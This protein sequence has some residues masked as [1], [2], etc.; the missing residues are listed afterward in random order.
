MTNEINLYPLYFAIFICIIFLVFIIS[1]ENKQIIYLCKKNILFS[2]VYLVIG[3]HYVL[4]YNH[5]ILDWLV[6]LFIYFIFIYAFLINIISIITRS[7]SL[8]ICM[9]LLENENNLTFNQLKESYCNF[10]SVKSILEN[11]LDLMISNNLIKMNNDKYI[12]TKKGLM[13]MYIFR[14]IRKSLNLQQTLI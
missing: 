8:N 6:G 3:I 4:N 2:F 9:T 5:S 7:Y 12:I 1:T 10:K 11:R 13:L 14:F